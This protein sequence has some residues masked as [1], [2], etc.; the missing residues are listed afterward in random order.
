M[1]CYL[2]PTGSSLISGDR[3]EIELPGFGSGA[4]MSFGLAYQST[5]ANGADLTCD[6]GGGNTTMTGSDSNVFVE[7]I[8]IVAIKVSSATLSF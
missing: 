5:S 7:E 4:V 1:I 6:A 3:S 2:T 8:F